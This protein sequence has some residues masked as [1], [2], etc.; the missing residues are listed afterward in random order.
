MRPR[1][2]AGLRFTTRQV[3]QPGTGLEPG[4]A[5][6]DAFAK[7]ALIATPLSQSPRHFL[8]RHCYF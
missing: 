1:L 7:P 2:Y 8:S 3:L 4:S 6:L 5:L